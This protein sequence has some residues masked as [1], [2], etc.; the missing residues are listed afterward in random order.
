MHIV[1]AQLVTAPSFKTAN[2]AKLLIAL[3]YTCTPPL[4]TPSGYTYGGKINFVRVSTNLLMPVDDADVNYILHLQTVAVAAAMSDLLSVV[5]D[6]NTP[7]SVN[8]RPRRVYT[9]SGF[10]VFVATSH[11]TDAVTECVS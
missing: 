3:G 2:R 5:R 11:D 6:R 7:T 9:R 10:A 8:R 1:D 4:H